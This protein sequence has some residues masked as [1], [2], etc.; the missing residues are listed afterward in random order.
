MELLRTYLQH[1]ALVPKA[2]VLLAALPSTTAAPR[3]FA[4]TEAAARTREVRT[5]PLP[6]NPDTTAVMVVEKSDRNKDP[7]ILCGRALTN[8][9]V[10]NHDSISKLHACFVASANGL[11]L[12]DL[13]SRNGTFVN[14]TPL[15]PNE[16]T[17]LV[18]QV[19]VRFGECAMTYFDAEAFVV[20]LAEMRE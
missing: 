16:E 11:A 2:P 6:F 7:R 14:D 15:R 1:A 3:P 4:T 18:E 5:A 13:G 19:N 10:I 17:L 20:L 12:V 8:D 9:V